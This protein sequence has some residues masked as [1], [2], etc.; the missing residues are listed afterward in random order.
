MLLSR[1]L[2]DGQRMISAMMEHAG[3]LSVRYTPITGSVVVRYNPHEVQQEEIILRVAFFLSLDHEAVPVRVL[4]EPERQD[5]TDSSIYSAILLLSALASR[6]LVGKGTAALPFDRVAG[7]STALAI[8]I[9]GWKEMRERGY[10]DPEVLSLGYLLTSFTQNN[11]LRSSLFTWFLTFGRHLVNLPEMGVTVKPLEIGDKEGS[12][13]RYELVVEPDT[14]MPEST[15]ILGAFQALVKYVVTGGAPPGRRTLME[16][17]R[18]VSKVHGEV[19]EGL[20]KIKGGI[21]IQIR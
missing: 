7:A 1:E 12:D 9:H 20:G 10:F 3:M 21:P 8:L 11:Y 5:L 15:R 16:E 2:Q 19:L 14:E 18:E 4:A 13:F 17:I 6:L